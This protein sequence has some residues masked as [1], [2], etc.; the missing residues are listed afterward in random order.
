MSQPRS[1]TQKIGTIAAI[2]A[3]AALVVVFAA[4]Y[5]TSAPGVCA[6]CH[7]MRDPVRSWS[8]GA[9]TTVGCP[10]CHDEPRPWYDVGGT[11]AER[12]NELSA[13][14]AIH[15]AGAVSVDESSEDTSPTPIPDE[16][17][18]A[19]HDMSR[20][21]TMRFGTLIDHAEHAERN[22]SCVSCHRYTGHPDP[23]AERP[24]L[25]M[26]QCFD[27]HGHEADAK[28]PGTCETCH[29]PAFSLRPVSHN[30][31]EVWRID[32]G[33]AA[34]SDRQPCAMCHEDEYCYDCHKLDMPHPDTWAAG[35][36]HHS[37]VAATDRALCASCH[38]EKP[39]LCSMC[40]H[41]EYDPAIGDWV[42]QHPDLVA[43]TGVIYC[44]ECHSAQYCIYCHTTGQNPEEDSGR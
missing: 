4:D 33:Q 22:G 18:L 6:S 42:K 5:A 35:T 21:I 32:H 43:K 29:P 26:Q 20:E 8:V 10:E 13:E 30:E 19:C 36:P 25:L 27:C 40:H 1:R 7:E 12:T 11:L 2:A 37:D 24:I 17:C 44:T 39:D 23:D 34:L 9:H 14:W 15:R 41:K 3:A 28:A 16:A 38:T 31:R